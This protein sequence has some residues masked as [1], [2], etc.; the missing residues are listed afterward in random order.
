MHVSGHIRGCRENELD[1]ILQIINAAAEAYR[2]T[3]PADCWK[4]PYMPLGELEHE[5]AA[6]VNFW[7][8]ELGRDLTGVMGIQSVREVTLIRHAYVRPGHQQHGIGSALLNH[9]CSM[10][11]ETLLVGTWAAATW[12]IDFYRRHGFT[13]LPEADTP[14]LLRSYWTISQRQLETSVVLV[15]RVA[16]PELGGDEHRDIADL[17][18][19]QRDR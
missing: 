7:G 15:R 11:S 18:R 9:L 13:L 12:A 5:I 14:S 3:I 6:G 19:G 8:Y 17:I 10:S 1:S 4:E 2:H 16:L